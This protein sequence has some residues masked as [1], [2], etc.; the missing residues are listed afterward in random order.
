[1]WQK[2]LY[3]VV[4]EIDF[5]EQK[6]LFWPTLRFQNY[7]ENGNFQKNGYDRNDTSGHKN[8]ILNRLNDRYFCHITIIKWCF[9]YIYN[10]GKFFI[11]NPIVTIKT[12]HHPLNSTNL[13]KSGGF[14]YY[15]VK[16]GCCFGLLAGH[17]LV[18]SNVELLLT[19]SAS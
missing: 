1:M 11:I 4:S 2:Y 12:Y 8:P 14:F 16:C 6:S 10:L 9:F 5:C 18:L 3:K 17:L 15:L 19:W 7:I 13:V